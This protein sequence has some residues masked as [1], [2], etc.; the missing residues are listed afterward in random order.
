VEF[1]TPQLESSHSFHPLP[2]EPVITSRSLAALV[3][4]LQWQSD[5]LHHTEELFAHLNVWRDLDL[6]PAPLIRDLPRKKPGDVLN[7][8]IPAGKL[9]PAYDP[10]KRRFFPLSTFGKGQLSPRLGRFYPQGLLRDFPYSLN[11]FRCVGL[12][13]AD[14]AADLN[15]PLAGQS[16]DL[17]VTVLGSHRKKGETGGQC[18]DWLASL[19]DGPGLQIRWHGQPT[20]FFPP[21][22]LQRTDDRPDAG[23]YLQPRFVS[24]LDPRARETISR[25]YGRLLRPGMLILDLMSSWQ[26]HL[27][28]ALEPLEVVGL[29]LNE[30]ELRQNPQLTGHLI[31]DLNREP[32]IPLAAASFEAVI[33]TVSVEYLIRPLEVFAAIK[34][35]LKPDGLFILTFSNRWFPPKVVQIWTELLDFERLGLV[36]EYFFRTGGFYDLATYSSRGWPRPQDDKYFPQVR[37][38]DPVFAVWGRKA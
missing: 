35:L 11:L 14:L 33:C 7:L 16:L 36:L 21:A 32:A 19:I 37:F 31:H 10:D 30:A 27:P 38:S 4:Q 13:A 24:H 25:L 1:Q 5:G 8:H 22:A 6:C 34:R 18:Q 15:H 28:A 3:W 2:S 17:A 29:G 20:D 12:T 26:S 23:F 9:L